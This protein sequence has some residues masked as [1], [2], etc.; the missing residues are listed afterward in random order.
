MHGLATY[1]P[2][3]TQLTPSS[4]LPP[5]SSLPPSLLCSDGDV[6]CACAD[7]LSSLAC[8]AEARRQVCTYNTE[9]YPLLHGWMCAF[10]ACDMCI[11]VS[12]LNVSTLAVPHIVEAVCVHAHAGALI[13]VVQ[14]H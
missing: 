10:T 9:V 7:A 12:Q 8:D 11:S 6:L 4:S 5:P 1:V 2:W 3:V 14:L 13:I